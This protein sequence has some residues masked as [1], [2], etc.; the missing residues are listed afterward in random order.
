MSSKINSAHTRINNNITQQC[1]N[2]NY[3]DNFGNV[4]YMWDIAKCPKYCKEYQITTTFLLAIK[5][6]MAVN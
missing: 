5:E 2:V 6:R 3:V 4:L 1:V